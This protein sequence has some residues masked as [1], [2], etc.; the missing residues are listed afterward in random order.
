[1]DREEPSADTSCVP[2]SVGNPVVRRVIMHR[3]VFGP[4]TVKAHC[5]S[6]LHM[7][8]GGKQVRH[9]FRARGDSSLPRAHS[10][11]SS[12]HRRLARLREDRLRMMDVF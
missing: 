8:S 6:H 2:L 9:I 1:M 4:T 7:A 10:L 5:P 11:H 12:A 3:A